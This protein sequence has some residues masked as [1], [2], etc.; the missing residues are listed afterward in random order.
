MVTRRRII[1]I[2]ERIAG[3]LPAALPAIRT[4]AG[5]AA[6]RFRGLPSS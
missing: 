6:S 1:D 5:R 3:G 4:A 2:T